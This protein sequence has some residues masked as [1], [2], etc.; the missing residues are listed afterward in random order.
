M[1]NINGI[2]CTEVN[3]IYSTTEYDKFKYQRGNRQLIESNVKTLIKKIKEKGYDTAFPVVVNKNMEIVDGQHRFE[4][5]RRLGLPIIFCF[6][7]NEGTLQE[8][9]DINNT[10]RN[11]NLQDFI[12]S[13]AELEYSSYITFKQLQEHYKYEPAVVLAMLLGRPSGGSD[14]AKIKDG[15]FE[16][17]INMLQSFN[18]I[19]NE[20]EQLKNCI[21]CK[22]EKTAFGKKN[23]VEA[24]IDIRR[25]TN[26]NFK[27]MLTVLKKDEGSFI[28]TEPGTGAVYARKKSLEQLYNRG[29][30]D[31]NKI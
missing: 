13:Y 23:F 12:D 22:K 3:K 19:N 4:A 30:S 8:T 20:F 11:W 1:T 21:K 25:S 2:N 18:I 27:R 24:Y 15:T 17:T 29:L 14:T 26:F 28:S 6:S 31:K 5:C 9:I 10:R 7:S 16:I